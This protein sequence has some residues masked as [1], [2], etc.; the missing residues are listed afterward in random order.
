MMSFVLLLCCSLIIRSFGQTVT[1]NLF[2]TKSEDAG[3]MTFNVKVNGVDFFTEEQV[4][5]QTIDYQQFQFQRELSD[6]VEVIFGQSSLFPGNYYI[7]TVDTTVA[8]FNSQTLDFYPVNQC[9]TQEA[10]TFTVYPVISFT[11]GITADIYINGELKIENYNGNAESQ[12]ILIEKDDLINVKISGSSSGNYGMS[13]FTRLDALTKIITWTNDNLATQMIIPSV[14]F[15][16]P[17]NQV[18]VYYG[19]SLP[20][21]LISYPVPNNFT[22]HFYYAGLNGGDYDE[23]QEITSNTDTVQTILIPSSIDS[24]GTNY[25]A[26][27][28]AGSDAQY[29]GLNSIFVSVDDT[30]PYSITFDTT[31]INPSYSAGTSVPVQLF[32]TPNPGNFMVQLTCG[33]LDPAIVVITSNI[34]AQDFLIPDNFYGI[35]VFSIS[36]PTISSNSPSIVIT[37]PV[38][39]LKPESSDDYAINQAI[40][41]IPS[42][43]VTFP[44]DLITVRQVCG[45]ITKDYPN[46]AVNSSFYAHPPLNYADQCTFSTLPN[47]LY[48]A[49]SPTVTI[50]ITNGLKFVKAPSTLLSVQNFVV[51]IDTLGWPVVGDGLISLELDCE[52]VGLVQSWPEVT[53]NTAA[54]LNLNAS[55]LTGGPLSCTLSTL[56]N[57]LYTSISSAVTVLTQMSQ[58][59]ISQFIQENGLTSST[60]WI[61]LQSN[62]NEK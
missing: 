52:S 37:Q 22:V 56:P 11:G 60:K 21:S 59:E 7:T 32:T 31:L 40:L 48:D 24:F 47:G 4:V 6:V 43:Q 38:S 8:I 10:C 16:F 26:V 39:F 27:N 42:A 29:S 2:V 35:C 57:Q 44:S 14:Y 33:T 53:L 49:A 23:T 12:T 45:T 25:F 41:V 5:T 55:D 58:A 9:T 54:I 62:W 51:R 15:T 28:Y 19:T 3:I 17:V 46:I 13:L 36:Y 50:S 18:T 20:I 34:V 1:N 61:T 30:V